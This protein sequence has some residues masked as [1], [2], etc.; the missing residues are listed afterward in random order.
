MALLLGID[1]GQSHTDAVLADDTGR[2]L[3]RGTGGPAN[4]TEEPGGVERLRGAVVASTAGALAAAGLGDADTVAGTPFL[5]VHCAMT[6]ADTLA[7][8]SV[9]APLLRGAIKLRVGHDAPA[10]LWGATAGEPGIVV[11]SGTGSV[12]YGEDAEGQGLTAGGWGFVFGDEGSA[13][14]LARAAVQASLAADDGLGPETT[15]GAALRSGLGMADLRTLITAFYARTL[16][17]DR[18][19]ACARLVEQAADAG[20][21]VAIGL[22][23][24][25][26]SALADLV[27]AIAGRLALGEAPRVCYAGGAFGMTRLRVAFERAVLKA[28]PQARLSLPR[29]DPAVGA[30][31]GAFRLAGLDLDAARWAALAES[32]RRPGPTR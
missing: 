30:L 28:Y 8:Q 10:A 5:A 15:M 2:I 6:G 17:R 27:R 1:G 7:K 13:F 18:L 14:G 26:A 25:A 31:I 29:F 20:D 16:D 23:D 3:G 11:I 21:P 12:A 32:A 22:F 4:H 9:I 24:E 19:A